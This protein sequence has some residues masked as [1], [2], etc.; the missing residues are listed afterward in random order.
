M[1]AQLMK[2]MLHILLVKQSLKLSKLAR[3]LL[4]SILAMSF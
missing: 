4:Y 2:P 1:G 3:I